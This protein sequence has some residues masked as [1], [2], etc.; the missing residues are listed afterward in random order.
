MQSR[1]GSVPSVLRHK[2][3]GV[4][5]RRWCAPLVVGQVEHETEV[6]VGTGALLWTADTCTI[7]VD[8]KNMLTEKL[9]IRI[10]EVSVRM[11]L[12]AV[13]ARAR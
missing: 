12:R 1:L 4:C 7:M 5:V 2:C 9:V 3:E 6:S 13:A 10:F 11:R 8:P